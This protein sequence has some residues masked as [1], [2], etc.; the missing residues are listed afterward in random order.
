MKVRYSQITILPGQPEKN[1]QTCKAEA[2]KADL[3]KRLDEERML[4]AE[5]SSCTSYFYAE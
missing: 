1:F 4:N 3:Q 2:E 5:L